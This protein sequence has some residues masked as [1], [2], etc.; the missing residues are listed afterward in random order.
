ME[1]FLFRVVCAI[2]FIFHLQTQAQ[3]KISPAVQEAVNATLAKSYDLKEKDLGI[4]KTKLQA[5]KVKSKYIPSLSATGGIAHFRNDAVL[6]LAPVNLPLLPFPLFDGT[7]SLSAKGNIV[8]AGLMANTVLFSGL[9]IPKAKQA[10]HTKA[11]AESLLRDA[12]SETVAR[13]VL[14]ALDNLQVL[15]EVDTLLAESKKRLDKEEKRVNK[16]IEAGL[17][18][19][20]DRDKIVLASLELDAKSKEAQG[21]KNVLL[22]QLRYLTGFSS[23][24]IQTITHHFE[25]IPL[26]YASELQ[27]KNKKELEAL[28]LFIEAQNLNISRE[29]NSF[30]PQV[31]AFGGL[32]YAR[33]FDSQV[34]L[35]SMPI[36][37]NNVNGKLD[38]LEVWPNWIV[39]VGVKW[40]IFEGMQRKH[41]ISE[42]TLDKELLV[43]KRK[44]SEEK[45]HLLLAK[46]KSDWDTQLEVL[47]IAEQR[48]HIATR[49][50]D[51]AIKQYEQGL[52]SISDRLSSENDYFSAALGV[53]KEIAKQR[54]LS[55]DLLITSGSFS[56]SIEVTP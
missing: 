52:L 7:Q 33:L 34:T 53:A 30:L 41:R 22:E 55:M 8:G 40:E 51:R 16:A 3:I 29:K 9:Q 44:D 15:R 5:D 54:E 24:K 45:L 31:A 18:I 21:T 26:L 4:A 23:E 25:R 32:Q 20:F 39:G 19:P 14:L 47:H 35:K 38:K 13:L 17:A 10:L 46:Q 49:N 36:T 1:K 37:G 48:L 27:I 12:E 28:D 6:D 50:L 42:A 11:E 2:G 43:N 56:E